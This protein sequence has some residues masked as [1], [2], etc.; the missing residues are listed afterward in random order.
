VNDIPNLSESELKHKINFLRQQIDSK[1]REIRSL[2]KE[3]SLHNKGINELRDNRDDLNKSVKELRATASDYRNKR[4]EVNKKIA[5]LKQQRNEMLS[6]QS[7]YTD[8][9]GELKKTRDDLNKIARGRIEFLNKTYEDQLDKFSNIDIPLE[10]EQ[11]LFENLHE[12]SGRLDAIH[13]ANIVHNEIGDV[14]GK[15]SE[16]KH[17]LDTISALIRDLASESQENHLKMLEIYK[18]VDDTKKESDDY[19]QRLVEIYKITRPIKDKIDVLKKSL[20]AIRE[21]L[22]SYLEHMSEIQLDKDKTKEDTKRIA[23]KEKFD[24]S[25]RMSLEDLRLL[26]ENDEIKFEK[27]S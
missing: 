18:E 12:L 7:T 19:H 6:H 8:K 26:I 23:A 4:D 11:S 24:K 3:M 21:E 22:D 27:E 15:V 20:S 14:Y 17:D 10:Y 5:E 25:G 16:F 2:F 9:I 13:K 1:D